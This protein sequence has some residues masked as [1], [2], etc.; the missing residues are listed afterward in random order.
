[1][2]RG[3]QVIPHSVAHGQ[4]L[5][6]IYTRRYVLNGIG[7]TAVA[8][9]LLHRPA[10]AQGRVFTP[11]EYGAKGDGV[12]NDTAAFERLSRAV[13]A[14]GGGTIQMRRAVYIVGAQRRGMLPNEVA[15]V[16]SGILG[17][18]GCTGPLQ[19]LGNGAVLRAAPGLRYGTFDRVTGA[20][21]NNKMP[22][23]DNR[24]MAIPYWS[25]IGISECTGPILIADI[26]LDG[27]MRALKIGGLYG[28]T[29]RQIPGNGIL[30]INNRGDEVVR[31]VHTHHQPLDGMMID[32]PDTVAAARGVTRRIENLRAE[33]NGR[34][35][36]SLIGGRGYVFTNCKFNHTG[37]GGIASAPGAGVDIEA[38][39]GKLNRD[40]RFENCEF[41][42]NSGCGMVADSGDSEGASFTG[43]TFIG[44][45]AWSAW[46]NKP[47]FRFNKC[48]FVGSIVRAHGDPDPERAAQFHDCTF[49][50]N[51]AASPTGKVYTGEGAGPIADLSDSKNV[52]FN[53]CVFRLTHQAVLPWSWFALYR[54]CTMSQRSPGQSHPKG[55]YFGINKVTGNAEFYG[56]KVPGT[57]IHNGKTYSKDDFGGPVW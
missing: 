5:A 53:R 12:T 34:Q 43:C 22:F 26:E 32:G 40:Y 13:G 20:A 16:P 54:D 49:L 3:G 47:R 17:F 57:L 42:D 38:E 37:R 8:A 39:N 51:P 6:M 50:D 35:G 28:D 21:T 48:R 14:N 1:M 29:G 33:Y 19:I 9:T 10:A 27:N 46:P 30:L 56:T 25:M 7:G 18:R 31:N 15:F 41:V 2:S 55:K 44:T 4:G 52:L 11:E 36:V 45:T 23:T 24:Q